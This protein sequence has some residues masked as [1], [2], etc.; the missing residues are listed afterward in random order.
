[1]SG[2]ANTYDTSLY[3]IEGFGHGS[4]PPQQIFT[5]VPIPLMGGLVLALVYLVYS[6]SKN[7]DTKTQQ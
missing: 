1:M 6:D 2:A 3:I 5:A 7:I 4:S